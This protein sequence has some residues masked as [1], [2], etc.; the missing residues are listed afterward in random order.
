[1]WHLMMLHMRVSG[2]V[3]GVGFALGVS[4]VNI[5]VALAWFGVNLLNVGLHSYGFTDNIATNLFIF[6][7][8]ELLFCFGIY[9][10]IKLNKSSSK[11]IAKELL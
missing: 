1:M 10:Y 5:I 3:K 6:I 2:L 9:F 7:S 8:I 11:L 4:L